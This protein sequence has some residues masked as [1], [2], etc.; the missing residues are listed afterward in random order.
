MTERPLN[1]VVG[2]VVKDGKCL[3]I[4]RAKEPYKDHWSI[5]GGKLE[6]GEDVSCAIERE[7]MEET[8]L[9]AKF[10]GLKGIVSEVL[11]DHKTDAVAGHF[12]I[13]V[14]GLDHLSGEP[15]EREEG[16]VQWFDGEELEKQKHSVIP[17]DYLMV[18]RF[19]FGE[20]SAIKFHTVR[21][22]S[23]D[24]GYKIEHTDL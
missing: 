13:W 10:T 7:I 14:C 2:S 5:P 18:K 11:R 12:L 20:S 4:R 1:I 15:V 24:N 17:S 23:T 22:R 19:I 16:N 21:M 3:L 8:G 6:Y 9:T